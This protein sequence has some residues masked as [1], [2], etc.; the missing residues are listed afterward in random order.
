MSTERNAALVRR[1]VDEVLH[2]AE[3]NRVDELVAAD[4]VDHALPP[5]MPAGLESMRQVLGMLRAVFPD[6]QYT[7]EDV[8]AADDKVV[9]R[10]TRRGTHAG[11]F[12]GLAATGRVAQWTGMDIFR[13]ADGKIVEHW[14]N[15]DQLGMMQQLGAQLVLPGQGQPTG[16]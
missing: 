15:F 7:I 10:F 13:L 11:P 6:L 3:P 12:M 9:V 8:I 5:Q 4:Y 14:T 16:L 2:G 1:F